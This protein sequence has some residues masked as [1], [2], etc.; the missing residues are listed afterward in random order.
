MIY[1]VSQ[2]LKELT[3]AVRR[4]EVD[5]RLESSDEPWESCRV[6]GTVTL[7]R[8]HRGVLVT[9]ELT[10]AIPLEC[11]F[12]LESFDL[13]LVLSLEEEF[14]PIIDVSSGLPVG[15]PTETGP[16]LIDKHHILD[17]SEAVRQA[18]VLTTP[19]SPRCGE[20]CRG[21]CPICGVNRNEQ[22]CSCEQPVDRRWT[23]LG[24]LLGDIGTSN[25]P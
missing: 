17:I 25:H 6:Q 16:F 14:F 18:I 5:E 15:V 19:I 2:L 23:A 24:Q 11:G 20:D 4:D 7:L 10:T 13:P 12:C 21:L 22:Q 8:T 1:N 9:G 3:G